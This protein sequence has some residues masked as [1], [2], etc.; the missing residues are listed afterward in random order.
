MTA[1]IIMLVPMASAHCCYRAS[2]A[3]STV[4]AV[5]DAAAADAA[6]AAAASALCTAYILLF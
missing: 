6:D 5:A 2:A 4:S 1:Q 3:A